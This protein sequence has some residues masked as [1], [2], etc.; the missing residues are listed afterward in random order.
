M[1]KRKNREMWLPILYKNI[2]LVVYSMG[3]I[4]LDHRLDSLSH[5]EKRISWDEIK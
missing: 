2:E 5:A 4:G 3:T 1:R